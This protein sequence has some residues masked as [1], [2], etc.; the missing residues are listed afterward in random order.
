MK[1]D[2]TS[3]IEAFIE[4]SEYES[5]SYNALSLFEKFDDEIYMITHNVLNDYI[6]ELEDL[7]VTVTLTDEEYNKYLYKPKLLSYDVYGTTELYFVIMIINRICNVKEFN[8]KK[9]KMLKLSTLESSISAIYNS[10]K[11]NIDKYSNKSV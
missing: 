10:E 7:S 1:S 5:I 3:T 6:E 8:F 2:K 4:S 9:L 11:H